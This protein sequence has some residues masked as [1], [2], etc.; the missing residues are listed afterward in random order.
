MQERFNRLQLQCSAALREKSAVQAELEAV[1]Q[2]SGDAAHEAAEA[3]H[4]RA[5]LAAV[6]AELQEARASQQAGG[7]ATEQLMEEL[8]SLQDYNAQL[9]AD[10]DAARAEVQQ[11]VERSTQFVNL[12]QMLAK[13]NMLVRQY[14][15]T[16]QANGIPMDDVDAQDD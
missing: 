1:M 11:R 3:G 9:A 2:S 6:E 10:L 7:G 4:L 13:K 12:R 16:L 14:R 5:Q 15:E 8:R